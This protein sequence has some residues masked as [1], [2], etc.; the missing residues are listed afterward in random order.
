MAHD[1]RQTDTQPLPEVANLTRRDILQRAS[2][3]VAAA[4][5]PASVDAASPQQATFKPPAGPDQPIGEVMN[6][7]STYM[8]QARDRAL[9]AKPLEQAKWHI[10]DTI[11]AMVSGSELPAGR[12]ATLFAR[13]YGGEKIATIVADTIVCGPFEAALVNG[14][15]AHADETDDSWPGGWHPGAGVVPAAMAAGEQFGISGAHF[16]RAVALGYDVGARMLI[17][18]RPGLPDSHKATHAIAGHWGALGA[19]A[20]AASLTPQQMRWAM[21]YTAQQ[22]SGIAS[23]FRDRDHIEKGFVYG[24][25]PARSGV[26]SALLVRA[27]WNGVDDVLS[28]RDNFLLASVPSGK[29]EPA[30]LIEKLGERYEI[31]GTNLKR[32][33]VGSP[34]QAPLDAME[35]LLKRQPIDP[36]QVQDILLRS[37]PG[38]VVDNSDP[39]D[40]NIQFAMALM[41]IDKTATFKSIHDKPRMQDP[42]ILALRKKVR[43]EAP[44]SSGGGSGAERLPLLQVTLS[45]GR[46]LTQDT[47]AVLGTIDNPM[48]RDQLAAKCRE[49]MTPVLGASQTQRLIDHILAL[50]QVKDIRELRPLLQRT[51][52][53]APPRLSEYP[54]HT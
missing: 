49:L 17:T 53:E 47:G 28:G 25:M 41:L 26:T 5:L 20:C 33:T 14:T 36:N 19:A 35:A 34:V 23:W 42:A 54:T 4:A 16:V 37:A 46:R 43:L 27:G 3:V 6:R 22:C 30:L 48:T 12:A 15:L 32:W 7:L 18:I 24:G 40:I 9:P 38:S 2:L 13:A 31:V 8:S 11:A 45:D 52:K 10:L 50:E 21:D 1:K 51:Y 39:P 44:S 29:V